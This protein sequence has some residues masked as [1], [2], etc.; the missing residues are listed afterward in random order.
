MKKPIVK[1]IAIPP[2]VELELAL[3]LVRA[4]GPK[5]QVERLLKLGDI[6]LER[7]DSELRLSHPRAGRKKKALLNTIAAHLQ[8]LIKG[9]KEGFKYRL[10]V[11]SVH[12]PISLRLDETQNKIFIK[13]F[14]GENKERE[15]Q[16]LKGVEVELK[17]DEIILSGPD[18]EAVA[19]SAAN[20]ERATWIRA[21]DR[22]VFQDGIYIVEKK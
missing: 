10:K 9:V 15:A 12:F 11:C 17:K 1:T 20:L 8:N 5:G 19:Q 2:E 14:L 6:K 4:K 22:R 3:P 18:L 7:L 13:N 21:K 16:L